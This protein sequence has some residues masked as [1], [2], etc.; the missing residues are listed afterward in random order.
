[1]KEPFELLHLYV[2]AGHNYFGHH[3]RPAGKIPI[4][5]VRE[6]RCIA[7][8]GIEGDRFFDYD[9]NHKGQITFFASEVYQSLCEQFGLWDKP[10]SVFRRNVISRGVDWNKLIGQEFEVQ[11]VR[12]L[13]TE[14][15]R[16]CHWMDHAC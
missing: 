14:E 6:A 4:R 12:F 5:E 9:A 2:S 7:G 15:C 1:M 8:Q 16:P 13:G 10:P 3:G 11:G